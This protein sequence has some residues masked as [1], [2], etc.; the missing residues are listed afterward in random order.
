MTI[1]HTVT[2][3]GATGSEILISTDDKGRA[4]W[5]YYPQIIW[6]LPSGIREFDLCERRK[7]LRAAHER[8]LKEEIEKE[9]Q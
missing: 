8:E 2:F 7:S 6:A 3:Q 1:H 9:G 5:N 4:I